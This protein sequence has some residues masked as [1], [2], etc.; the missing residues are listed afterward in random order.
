M[1]TRPI[2]KNKKANIKCEHCRSF[3]QSETSCIAKNTNKCTN[4]QSP[5]Y[6]EGKVNY[7]NRCKCFEWAK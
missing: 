3:I 5:K 1:N 4:A 2:D 7:W 6:G